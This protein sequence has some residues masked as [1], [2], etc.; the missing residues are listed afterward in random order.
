MQHR[1]TDSADVRAEDVA[2]VVDVVVENGTHQST[3]PPPPP[4]VRVTRGNDEEDAEE[5]GDV[6]ASEGAFVRRTSPRARDLAAARASLSE[7]RGRGGERVGG[8][9]ELVDDGGDPFEDAA[10]TL[11]RRAGGERS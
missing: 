10:A 7:D 8:G 4:A 11:R 9:G 1:R 5:L 6:G 3:H 2:E